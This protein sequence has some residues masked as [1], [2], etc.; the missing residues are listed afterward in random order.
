MDFQ[1]ANNSDHVILLHGLGR[2]KKIMSK[3]EDYLLLHGFWTHNIEYPSKKYNVDKLASLVLEQIYPLLLEKNHKVHFVGHS[4][5]AILVRTILQRKKIENLGKVVLLAPPNHGSEIIN[6]FR[7]FSFYKILYGPASLELSTDSE[8]L[9][10]LNS[11]S[12][13]DYEVG[14][15]AGDY[16]L[17]F[18]FSWFLLPGLDDGKVTVAST[19]L[20]FMTDHIIVHASHAFIP[21]NPCAMRQVVYFLRRGLFK[22]HCKI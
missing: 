1:L 17:D 18:L 15:I 22:K 8:L 21:R 6:F 16:S 10:S 9:K 3:L 11:I 20:D 7:K 19:K 12:G 4:L 5:G 14:V 13:V 2:N